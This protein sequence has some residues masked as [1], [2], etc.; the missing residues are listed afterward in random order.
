MSY[1]RLFCKRWMAMNLDIR[2]RTGLR[3]GN[4]LEDCNNDLGVCMS[5]PAMGDPFTLGINCQAEYDMCVNDC[6]SE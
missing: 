1:L 6:M 2:V 5:K 4:C 3:A